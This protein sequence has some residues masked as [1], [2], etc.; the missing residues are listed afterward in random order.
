MLSTL[1][2]ASL[3]VQLPNEQELS[4]WDQLRN[5]VVDVS[6]VDWTAIIVIGVFFLL[7]LFR[8]FVWQATRMASLV[9]AYVVAS[10]YGM[11][12]AEL[13]QP[14]FSED[15]PVDRLPLY[16]S[17]VAI[18]I[19][20]LALLSVIAH[21]IQ[22]LIK[23]SGLSFY[24]RVGGGVLGFATGAGIMIFILATLLM[25]VPDSWKTKETLRESRAMA[26]SKR[27]LQ[28]L[29]GWVPKPLQ[30][31]FDVEEGEQKGDRGRSGD[32][33]QRDDR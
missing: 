3:V 24:D 10:I 23:K 17:Y 9:I 21:F 31:V 25:F 11:D 28:T 15:T 29:G 26:F 19:A 5:A 6:W 7:G 30:R 2:A 8:G 14:W 16:L 20:S 12:G 27:T 18:F 32:E 4:L 33:E 13:I 1:N 22:K